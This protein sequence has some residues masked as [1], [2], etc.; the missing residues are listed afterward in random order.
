M[1]ASLEAGH[2]S[3][4]L[5]FFVT[6]CL[7]LVLLPFGESFRR[8]FTLSESESGMCCSSIHVLHSKARDVWMFIYLSS[9]DLWLKG[10]D[11][12]ILLQVFS[13]RDSHKRPEEHDA[14]VCRVGEES[15]WKIDQISASSFLLF[16]PD[17]ATRHEEKKPFENRKFFY[18][19]LLYS[20]TFYEIRWHHWKRGTSFPRLLKRRWETMLIV[21]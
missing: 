6:F 10:L 16:R 2:S 8:T 21:T 7:S 18:F 4:S 12:S 17:V 19:L 3:D 15:A 1:I 9:L 14:Y 20:S 13:I 5:F 11:T